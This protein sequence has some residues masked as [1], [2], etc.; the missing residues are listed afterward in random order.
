MNLTLDI[1]VIVLLAAGCFCSLT[2][3][4]GMLRLPDFYSRAHASGINDTLGMMLF[5]AALG[6]ECARHEYSFTVWTRLLMIAIVLLVTGPAAT[7][8][9]ANAAMLDGLQPWTRKDGKP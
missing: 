2:A 1:A 7:H 3:A 8:A 4:A 9:I 5:I 6:V